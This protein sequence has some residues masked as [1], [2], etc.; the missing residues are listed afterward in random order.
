VTSELAP[1]NTFAPARLM[2]TAAESEVWILSPGTTAEERGAAVPFSEKLPLEY[3]MAAAV[4]AKA[5]YAGSTE[6]SKQDRNLDRRLFMM[7]RF[8]ELCHPTLLKTSR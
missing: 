3:S 1:T 8:Y 6:M 7:F 5:V 2:L 4:S